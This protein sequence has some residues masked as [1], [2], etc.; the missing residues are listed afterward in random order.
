[1]VLFKN[2]NFALDLKHGRGCVVQN[3]DQT[4]QPQIPIQY[5]SEKAK[6]GNGTLKAEKWNIFYCT[7]QPEPA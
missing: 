2:S 4:P 7:E 1:M 6:N 3:N 5:S